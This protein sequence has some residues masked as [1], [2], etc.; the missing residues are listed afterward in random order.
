M[1]Y[2]SNKKAIS[3]IVLVITIVVMTILASTVIV[4]LTDVSI[5]GQANNSVEATEIAQEKEAI[6]VSVAQAMLQNKKRELTKNELE[7]ILK[8]NLMKT[9]P[10]M[11]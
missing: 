4:S 9:M 10:Y 11:K 1:N 6:N 7:S 8:E 2:I 3:L 5:I